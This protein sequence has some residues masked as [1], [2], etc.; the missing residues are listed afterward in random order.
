MDGSGYSTPIKG[1]DRR[2]DVEFPEPKQTQ[3]DGNDQHKY[4]ENDQQVV[5]PAVVE[6]NEPG[7]GS[8]AKRAQVHGVDNILAANDGVDSNRNDQ[9]RHLSHL[10]DQTAAEIFQFVSACALGVICLL[11]ITSE[12]WNE[13]HGQVHCIR[14]F[15]R[16][17]QA[18]EGDPIQSRVH[19]V[20]DDNGHDGDPK[21]A[22]ELADGEE[23]TFDGNGQRGC[24][25]ENRK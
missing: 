16:Q 20:G 24:P 23:D 7:T 15:V 2:R 1:N 3:A 10:L 11:K 25:A 19:R 17:T 12:G 8:D 9:R 6:L 21:D 22:H 18:A 4:G 14:K 13:A 5:V